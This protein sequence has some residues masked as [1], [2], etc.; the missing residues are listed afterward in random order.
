M[1]YS[2]NRPEKESQGDGLRLEDKMGT[3]SDKKT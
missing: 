1:A 2:T 3:T